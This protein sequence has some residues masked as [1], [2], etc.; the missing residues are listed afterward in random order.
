MEVISV[1]TKAEKSLSKLYCWF[2]SLPFAYCLKFQSLLHIA[3]FFISFGIPQSRNFLQE[4]KDTG[5]YI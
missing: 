3:A 2:L 1:Y 5:A 4:A